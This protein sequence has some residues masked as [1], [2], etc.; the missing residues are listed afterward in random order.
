[1]I[2]ALLGQLLKSPSFEDDEKT[3]LASL[4]NTIFWAAIAMGLCFCLITLIW[5]PPRLVRLLIAGMWILVA[6]FGLALA[7]VFLTGWHAFRV[8]R[9]GGIAVP[10]PPLPSSYG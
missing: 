9:D 2:R 10:P 1:M 7:A 8:R 4:Q 5:E 6:A 3:R